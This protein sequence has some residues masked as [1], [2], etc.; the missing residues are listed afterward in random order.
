[1][2]SSTPISYRTKL[3]NLAIKYPWITKLQVKPTPGHV[4]LIVRFIDLC[5]MAMGTQ[6]PAFSVFQVKYLKNSMRITV[7]PSCDVACDTA[8]LRSAIELTL[9]ESSIVC[10]HCGDY[11]T[12]GQ[13]LTDVYVC[14]PASGDL[15]LWEA[16]PDLMAMHS[17]ERDAV[18]EIVI[19]EEASQRSTGTPATK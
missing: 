9:R 15:V 18:F 12:F 6:S 10:P 14:C 3:K 11:Q 19:A 8:A 5:E 7:I 13:S 17:E 1:M 4:D 2:M 16:I